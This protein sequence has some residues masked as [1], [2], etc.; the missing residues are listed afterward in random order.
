MSSTHSAGAASDGR[1][2]RLHRRAQELIPAGCHTYSKGDDQFPANAPRLIERGAGCRCWDADGRPW[3]DFGMGLRAV[4]LGHAYEPVLRRVRAELERGS[5]FTRPAPI[6]GELAERLRGLIPC[7]EMSKFAKNGSDVTTAAVRLARAYTGR[8]LVAACRTNPFYSFDDWWIATTPTD[9]G[10]PQAIRELTLTFAYNDLAGAEALFAKYPGQIAS[11][12]IEPVAAEP[13]RDNFLGALV[14]LAH[15]H[16]AVVI[17]D[18]MI[19]GF[20]FDLRGAQTM[21]GVEP[22]LA[23]FGKAM[24]NGFSVA[25]L[26]GHK[27]I[28]RL[29]GLEHD[30]PRVF[31][32]SATHGAETHG[33][34]AALA[35]I[36]ELES[37][38]V[39]GHVARLGQDLIARA[40][41]MAA[42]AGLGDRI[43]AAGHVA[44]PILTFRDAA[45]DISAEFRTLFMQEMANA[46]ILMPYIAL[47]WSH[48]DAEIDQWA[49]AFEQFLSV[50]RRGLDQ[51]IASV[52]RGPAVKPVFRRFN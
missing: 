27:E 40:N 41:R 46:G 4:I 21:F 26:C 3:L 30:H 8:D 2:V 1:E 5:N 31:L 11:V 52:L 36:D 43:Q 34:A 24:S 37:H 38:N 39:V 33:L 28:M 7:A 6:E 49:G 12:I 47:S 16:G 35:T 9:A 45:G 25:A 13:P 51:G 44:S 15:R 22:D 23:T 32:M 10:I 18:E 14:E 20:R 42:E 50:Y 29:G 17:F 48:G 19:S